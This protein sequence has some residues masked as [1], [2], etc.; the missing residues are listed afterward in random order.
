MSMTEIFRSLGRADALKL[1]EEAASLNGTQ[2][3]DR[4]HCVPAFDPTKDYSGFPVS[5]PVA[6]EGQV[7]LL[8][9][10][11]NAA[12]YVGR[13]STMRA[14]WGLCH[15]TN[16]AKA[17]SWVDPLGTSGMYMKDEVY[18][19][20]DG[21][22]YRCLFDNTIHDARMYPDGWELVGTY[23]TIAS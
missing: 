2:I 11:H 7:W 6:D 21:S 4:E 13:P 12:N 3:I 9:Q 10:P 23:V 14:Q 1:R 20:E 8:I 18:K 5:S 22:V 15:T 17:K 16:P 19:V